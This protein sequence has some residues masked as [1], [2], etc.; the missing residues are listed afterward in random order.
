MSEHRIALHWNRATPDF[1]LKSYNRDHALTFKNGQSLAMSAAPAYKGNPLCVDP[2]EALVGSL[3]SCHMLTFLA[4]AAGRTFTVDSYE[5]N[6]VGVLEKNA[7]GRLAITRV[8]LKP[9]IRFADPAP[10]ADELHDIHEKAH[11]NCFIANSVTT[12]VTI[13]QPQ[14][15]A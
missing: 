8:T 11:A 1:N 14:L 4:I 13:E 15:T 12:I 2:E 6:A 3:A 5:D 7:D 9:Q 10:T